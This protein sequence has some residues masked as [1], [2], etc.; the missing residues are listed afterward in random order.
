MQENNIWHKG[1]GAV[2]IGCQTK[3]KGSTMAKEIGAKIVEF[4]K[5]GDWELVKDMQTEKRVASR[6]YELREEQ[7]NNTESQAA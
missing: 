2:G 3:R 5:M 4:L 6:G 1:V 7:Y